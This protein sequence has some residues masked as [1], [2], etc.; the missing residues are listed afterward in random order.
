VAVLAYQN[1][2]TPHVPLSLT[3]VS[4]YDELR[5]WRGLCVLL[6]YIYRF[7]VFQDPCRQRLHVVSAFL[8]GRASPLITPAPKSPKRYQ[9]PLYLGEIFAHLREGMM[10]SSSTVLVATI[11]NKEASKA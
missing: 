1:E 6:Q 2:L 7:Q 4:V 9:K 11:A 3:L 5:V 8:Q 10:A